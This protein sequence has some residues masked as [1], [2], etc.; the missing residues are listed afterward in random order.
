M[1]TTI[2]IVMSITRKILSFVGLPLLIVFAAV[3]AW[4]FQ[5]TG[6]ATTEKVED[7]TVSETTESTSKTNATW[8]QTENGWEPDG[9]APKCADPFKI[10][11]PTKNLSAATSILYPGQKRGGDYKPHG[12]F[13]FGNSK[14]ED[15]KVI[16]PI[17]SNLVNASRYLAEEDGN[18][19]VQYLLTFISP[20]G[21][22]YRF[23]HVID[24]VPKIQEVMDTLPKATSGDSRTTNITPQIE[25]EQGEL[26]ANG[27]GIKEGSNV[28]F[29]FGMYDLRQEKGY[30]T[31]SAEFLKNHVGDENALNGFCWFDLLPDADSTLVKSLPPG[32][33]ETGKTSDTCS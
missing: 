15:I 2:N 17:N 1:L 14:N 4:S 7:T 33:G 13:R 18:N 26:V 11:P 29:D 19:E 12:G 32:S 10:A 28:F 5:K 27:V 16:I 8:E 25:F 21:I 23:D 22:S 6:T 9:I 31:T 20:C 24:L 3:I 30:K